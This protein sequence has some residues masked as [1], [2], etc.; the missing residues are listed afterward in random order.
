M[1]KIIGIVLVIAI[2]IG[3]GFGVKRF[4]EGPPQSVNGLLVIGTEKEV[5]KVKQLYKNK[6]KQTVDYKMKFIV[7][8]KGESNLKYAVINKTTAEQFVKK[9]IIRARKDP[10]SLSI[11]SEPVY[12][13]K[14][15]N[16]SLNLLY[17]FDDKDMVDHK[18]ELN[19]QMIPVHYVK[20][21]AW[22]GYIPMDLVI[23]NDQTYDELTDPESIITLFQLNSGSKFDYKDK[24]KTNQVF[25][26]IKGVYSDSEDKVNFVDIQD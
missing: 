5:N 1:K 21:Q 20:H 19:G 12:E 6:T 17:S 8:K 18:I 9:G 22:V 7:T 23:L 25:K 11:I 2:F 24:E 15:L 14:E 10:N 16:G 26:E 13:I 3:I 4:I